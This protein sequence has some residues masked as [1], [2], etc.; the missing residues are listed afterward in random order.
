MTD[1]CGWVSRHPVY[2]KKTSSKG[3]RTPVESMVTYQPSLLLSISGYG[4][5]C[6]TESRFSGKTLSLASKSVISL[7]TLFFDVIFVY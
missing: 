6:A 7:H 2:L 3:G 1:I 5:F 4:S